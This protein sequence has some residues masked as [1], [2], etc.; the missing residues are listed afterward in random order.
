MT[1]SFYL[2]NEPNTIL[3]DFNCL[4]LLLMCATHKDYE[5]RGFFFSINLIKTNLLNRYFKNHSF[6][7]S[8]FLRI[9]T[10]TSIQKKHVIIS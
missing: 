10:Q 3:G 2:I 4:N 7:G 5:V 1:L 8:L 9:F 6:S